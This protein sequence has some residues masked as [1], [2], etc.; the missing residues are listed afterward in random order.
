LTELKNEINDFRLFLQQVNRLESPQSSY[1]N[2]ILSTGNDNSEGASWET[3]LL[4]DKILVSAIE[5]FDLL[6]FNIRLASFEA[7]A[8]K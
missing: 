4:K 6:Q 8:A 1:F 5:R 3:N 7:I 2:E